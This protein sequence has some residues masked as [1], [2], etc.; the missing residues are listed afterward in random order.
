MPEK[1]GIIQRL[2]ND[3]AVVLQSQVL[4][5]SLPDALREVIQNS[6]DANAQN[7]E[8]EINFEEL[9]F[10]VY[11]D[12]CGI[13][14]SNLSLIG[15]PHYTS[16]L[17]SL[18]D[19]RSITTF[20]FRGQALHSLSS[21]STLTIISKVTSYNSSFSTVIG[22]SKRLFEPKMLSED[23]VFYPVQPNHH[24]TIVSVKDLFKNIPVRHG[25]ATKVPDHKILEDIREIILHCAITF[26]KVHFKI[27]K[28]ISILTRSLICDLKCSDEKTQSG[29]ITCAMDN[30]YGLSLRDRCQNLSVEFQDYKVSCS[31][32]KLPVQSKNYQF[33][34]WNNR[35]LKQKDLNKEINKNFQNSGFGSQDDVLVSSI[36][37]HE[38]SPKK[39]RS[40][41]KAA[42][43]VG[44]PYSKY[45]VFVIIIKGK[46]STSDLIQDPSKSLN[47]T[48]HINVVTPLILKL[49]KSFL[50]MNGYSTGNGSFL[51]R[52]KKQQIGKHLTL[53]DDHDDVDGYS[54]TQMNFLLKS[55]LGIKNASNRQ[56]SGMFSCGPKDDLKRPNHKQVDLKIRKLSYRDSSKDENQHLPK[57]KKRLLDQHNGDCSHSHRF[58]EAEE[59]KIL[60]DWLHNISVIGQVDDKFILVK[61]SQPSSKLFIIDQ[62]ACDER[63]KVEAL[64][65]EFIKSVC[66]PFFDLGIS[67]EDRNIHLKFDNSDIDL[68]RQY[69]KQCEVWGIRYFIL[70]NNIVHITH[71]PDLLVSKIDEDKLFL[72]KCLSQYINDLSSHKKLKS[73]SKDW[74]SNLQAIPSIIMDLINSKAC[75]SAV[76]FGK[77]LSK[78][79][80][81][82]LIKELVKCKQ[83]FQCAHGRPS[84]VP[85]C[86][87]RLLQ[88]INE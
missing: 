16:K 8:V 88:D 27:W 68:L 43:S 32:G 9:S 48:K 76:M 82:Q 36:S 87:L 40:P 10:T 81:E 46:L 78:P 84:I 56:V 75:R 2:D 80:C 50:K 26:P 28:K 7:I 67:V 33:I 73:L 74:W 25:Q 45:P 30:I 29:Q 57:P 61:L 23:S 53:T 21:I 59:V 70:S 60:K 1:N 13:D 69:Q 66:D 55:R 39:G 11:D 41:T 12:G 44:S 86:D 24:G 63:I 71:L 35:L 85:L 79:E 64:T 14:P 37:R 58:V 38:T 65:A 83:P 17:K 34:F 77:S 72:K 15:N 42:S 31:I 52:T 19:L 47:C 5:S 4:I 51:G 18:N 20:G 49:I 22:N 54:P 6:L 3:V 62:H